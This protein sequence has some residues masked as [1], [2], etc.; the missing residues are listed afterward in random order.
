VVAIKLFVEGGG[1][2]KTLRT[3]CREGFAEFL[4]KAGLKGSMPRIVAC[5]GRGSA[6]NDFCTAVAN[7]QP[8]R[9]NAS[10]K[11]FPSDQARR[12]HFWKLLAEKL[13]DPAFRKSAGGFSE[14]HGRGH[15]RHV[16]SAVLHRLPESLAGGLR[17]HYG[18]PY[19][20][21]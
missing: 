14:G 21:A 15:P 9:S 16:R 20:P 8:A 19:D 4:G 10:A 6:Y 18:T 12:E 3:A 13:K 17:R 2:S 7:G 5:G 1:D 11:T